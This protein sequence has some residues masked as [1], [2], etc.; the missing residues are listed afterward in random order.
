MR[1]PIHSQHGVAAVELAIVLIPML[2][3]CFGIT[4]LGRAL[5]Q[6]NGLVKATRGAA[7]YLSQQSLASP[8][9]GETADGIRLK[10]RSLA[11][12]G[13]FNCDQ[14]PALVPNLTLAQISVCDP[15]S[16]VG[17]HANVPTGEGTT[18]L[19]T[20]TIGAGDN[21]YDFTSIVPW[22]VPSI[23]FGPIGITMASST[24]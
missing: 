8:P 6:Y 14:T 22:V 19:V 18:S 16:C 11:L 2:V 23:T 4:E 20:V 7:R 21:G 13:A 3:L 15:V 5:Y 17:T 1:S 10:A 24:N 12:C 9:A